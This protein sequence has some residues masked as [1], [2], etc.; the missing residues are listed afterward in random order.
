MPTGTSENEKDRQCGRLQQLD[1]GGSLLLLTLF[2]TVRDSPD[3]R[4]I[5]RNTID[6]WA[7]L[8]PFG[9]QPLLYVV[10]AERRRSSED[11]GDWSLVDHA[12]RSGWTVR[13]YDHVVSGAT[14]SRVPVLRHMFIDA[15]RSSRWRLAVD[16]AFIFT[17][18]TSSQMTS[19]QQTL[20]HMGHGELG[21]GSLD[22][23]RPSSPWLLPITAHP[24][25]MR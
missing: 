24:A 18:L 4:T 19:S 17:H 9:V 8:R 1:G 7:A 2:T 11:D 14:A 23:A 3:R 12:R 5:H 16:G 6:N 20:F 13:P 21:H 25:K 15:E 10:D 22:S